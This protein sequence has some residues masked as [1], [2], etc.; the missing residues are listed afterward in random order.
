MS[1]IILAPRSDYSLIP[2]HRND[3]EYDTLCPG[4]MCPGL[5][6]WVV[7]VCVGGGGSHVKHWTNIGKTKEMVIEIIYV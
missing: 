7:N 5:N 4:D 6:I 3:G 2:C 1:I